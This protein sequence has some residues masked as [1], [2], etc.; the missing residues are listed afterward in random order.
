MDL[1][2]DVVST[3]RVPVLVMH[4]K[5]DVMYPVTHGRWLAEHIDDAELVEVDGTDHLPPR[6]ACVSPTS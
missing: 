6:T 3:I 5:G 4:A 2:V 1:D